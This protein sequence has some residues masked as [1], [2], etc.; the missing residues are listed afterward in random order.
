M[1]AIRILGAVWLTV[2]FC[3]A[4]SGLDSNAHEISVSRQAVEAELSSG[5]G[6]SR[7]WSSAPIP[8]ETVPVDGARVLNAEFFGHPSM[9]KIH[10]MPPTLQT[11]GIDS[12][13]ALSSGAVSEAGP[14]P[15]RVQHDGELLPDGARLVLT[16][17]PDPL[18]PLVL[19]TWSLFTT[20]INAFSQ[21]GFDDVF[22]INVIDANGPR[23]L[24]EARSSDAR[25]FPVSDRRA[26]DSGFDLYSQMPETVPTQ[27]GRGLPA[28]MMTGWRT[29]G[30]TVDAST[31]VQIEIE[32]RDVGDLLMDT[33]ALIGSIRL[34]G[35]IPT[36][37]V[38]GSGDCV[39][40]EDYCAALFPLPGTFVGN[41]NP[42]DP[43]WMCA[44]KPVGTRGGIDF[45]QPQEFRG[46][47][48]QAI[49]ADGSTRMPIVPT[50]SVERDEVVISVLDGDVPADGGLGTFGSEDRL[51]EITVP[52]IE[53]GQGFWGGQAQYFAPES[54]WRPELDLETEYG[55]ERRIQLQACFQNAGGTDRVCFAIPIDIVRPDLVYLA[56]HCATYSESESV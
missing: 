10:E 28:A 20:E 3:P 18:R 36:P 14:A 32:V 11:R 54:Y 22:R 5:A 47:S 8:L 6:T 16:I 39:N 49:V 41:G 21:L 13:L 50:I 43:P 52:V 44:L 53:L 34:S 25:F 37:L 12:A 55:R 56:T 19:I 42:A 2:A 51:E 15:G 35:T 24:V 4:K 40:A 38:R 7:L 31:P 29:S 48:V 27:Y 33:Q 30:F 1:K 26:A 45:S 17:E 9:V 23:P 46:G